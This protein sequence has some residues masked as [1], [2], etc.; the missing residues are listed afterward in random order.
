MSREAEGQ[1]TLL[2]CAGACFG[3]FV[4]L[5]V[6]ISAASVVR[7]DAAIRSAVHRFAS[8]DLTGLARGLSLLGSGAVVAT[9]SVMAF[10]GFYATGRRLPRANGLKLS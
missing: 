2:A 10:A 5:A 6:S 8:P 7:F 3:L 4:W 9:L 1:W